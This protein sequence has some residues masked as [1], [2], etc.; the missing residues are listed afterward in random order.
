MTLLIH[1]LYIDPRL[2][3]HLT[4]H[5]VTGYQYNGTQDN[6][7]I[8]LAACCKHWAAYD[9]EDKPTSRVYFNAEVNA[10]NWAETYSPMF[11]ECVVRSKVQHI[12]CSYNSINGIPTCGDKNILTTVLRDQWNFEG[13]VVS[14]YDAMAN[15][16]STHHYTNNMEEAVALAITSGC[17]QEGGGTSA[18]NQIPNALRDGLL[19]EN[20]INIAFKRLFRTRFMLGFFDPPLDVAY[21]NITVNTDGGVEGTKHLNLA[22]IVA[23]DSIS[24][25]KNKNNV[26]PLNPQNIKGIAV[27]G[28]QSIDPSLLP[29]NYGMIIYSFNF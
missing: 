15:I 3:A 22:R 21:N 25:Y 8:L 9:L 6:K 27:I 16:Y 11:R 14:D 20:D 24:L 2:A 10:I 7:Y 5:F 28:P 17:D 13:F 18:I 19:N 12:M 1:Y 29:G 23:Q 4:H 26:L